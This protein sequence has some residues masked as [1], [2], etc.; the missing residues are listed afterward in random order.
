MAENQARNRE[1]DGQEPS[2]EQI[3]KRAHELYRQRE[4]EFGGP[5]DD[6]LEAEAPAAAPV[7]GSGSKTAKA[8]VERGH[9]EIVVIGCGK[10]GKY[11]GKADRRN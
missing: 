8:R 11:L 10:A 6:W 9:H 5:L 4:R 3:W 2:D 1:T 7:V